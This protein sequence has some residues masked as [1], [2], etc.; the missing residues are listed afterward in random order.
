[1]RAS[2]SAVFPLGFAL[3]AVF[4]LSL[5]LA[6]VFPFSFQLS[7]VFALCLVAWLPLH[8]AVFHVLRLPFYVLRFTISEAISFRNLLP[9]ADSQL[10]HSVLIHFFR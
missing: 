3:S 9:I 4:A 2:L 1:L 7:P 6:A 8:S 5:Q 10:P